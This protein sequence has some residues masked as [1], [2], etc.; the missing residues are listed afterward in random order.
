MNSRIP[1]NARE[2]LDELAENNEE[3]IALYRKLGYSHYFHHQAKELVAELKR[4]LEYEI[5]DFDAFQKALQ[6]IEHEVERVEGEN[7]VEEGLSPEESAR[8]HVQHPLF[9]AS[10]ELF[11]SLLQ[12]GDCRAAIA[13][14]KEAPLHQSLPFNL[15]QRI[16][17]YPTK[18][19][20][21]NRLLDDL[22]E[23]YRERWKPI[24]E[25]GKARV[26]E[27]ITDLRD[28]LKVGAC[29][30]RSMLGSVANVV[31]DDGA[32]LLD[33]LAFDRKRDLD[34]VLW[35]SAYAQFTY[36]PADRNG[37][38]RDTVRESAKLYAENPWMCTSWLTTRLVTQ[39]LD[40]EFMPVARTAYWPA[41]RPW[42]IISLVVA[43]AIADRIWH[44]SWFTW[45]FVV[46]TAL[47]Y[48]W[49]WIRAIQKVRALGAIREEVGTGNYDGQE[50]GRR[51][52]NCERIG[53]QVPTAIFALLRTQPTDYLQAP[54]PRLG[55]QCQP[56]KT[57]S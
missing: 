49:P 44:F 47:L 23:I 36:D 53:V 38:F 34:E 14:V 13:A 32:F 2:F 52:R 19:D 51:L 45:V 15:R 26:L 9:L 12:S 11:D 55:K 7:T 21:F 8:R 42:I 29:D 16:K 41:K 56:H 46:I 31:D 35:N 18:P 1:S 40:S 54:H 57:V 17:A 25:N 5:A 39:L 30:L 6:E 24:G 4:L 27:A 50:V 33:D 3:I 48:A 28:A 10:K 43:T 20:T 22:S 37:A